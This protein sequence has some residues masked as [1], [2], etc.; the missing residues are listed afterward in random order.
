MTDVL[1]LCEYPT[2]LGGERSLLS[3]LE[4]LRSAGYAVAVACPGEGALADALAQGNVPTYPL[5]LHGPD[6]RRRPLEQIRGDL[7]QLF[8][9]TKPDLVH[10]NSL[11]T[12][13]IAGP[14]AAKLALPSVAHLRDIVKLRRSEVGDLNQHRRLIAVSRATRDA[15]VAQGLDPKTTSVVYNGVD[16]ARFQP[17]PASGYL[18]RELGLPTDSHLIGTIGQIALRKGLDTLVAAAAEV[19]RERSDVHFLV[20][21]DCYSQKAESRELL[22]SLH[23]A[24]QRGP[25]AG[26]LHLLGTRDDV[27]Q[28]LGELTLLVH[29]ARQE[30]FG[31][32]LL[33]AAA[34][35]LPVLASRVGGTPEIFHL[36]ESARLVPPDDPAA[37][38]GAVLELLKSEPARRSLGEAARRCAEQFSTSAAADGLMREYARAIAS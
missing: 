35:G 8:R 15:H 13:R 26:R 25:L 6:G 3:V 28:I 19:A 7:E 32:V 34:S 5:S 29:P 18:H 17:R 22:A 21:G 27:E 12:G 36:P 38:S 4:P 11:A 37:L 31:R 2:L 1:V 20:I 24:A 33:E 16:L 9:R 30:P 10:A 23:A 14:V